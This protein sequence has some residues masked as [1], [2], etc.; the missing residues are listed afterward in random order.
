MMWAFT[1][2]RGGH[3]GKDGGPSG[4]LYP[5]GAHR[6]DL[7]NIHVTAAGTMRAESSSALIAVSDLT[8]ADG[9]ALIIHAE[10]DG[11]QSQPIG[12]AGARIACAL[13]R[14]KT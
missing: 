7:P 14:P 10:R 6:G 13:F 4:L 8:D 5:D 9:A 2:P 1:R 3:I 12:G 11:W